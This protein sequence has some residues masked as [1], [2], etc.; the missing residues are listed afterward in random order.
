MWQFT[1]D[2]KVEGISGR[3]D[4]NYSYISKKMLNEK[5]AHPKL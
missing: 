1:S 3:A 5:R 2:C 4:M